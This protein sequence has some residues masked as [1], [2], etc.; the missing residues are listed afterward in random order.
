M[1]IN[2]VK[3]ALKERLDEIDKYMGNPPPFN[4]LK[5]TDMNNPIKVN[6]EYVRILDLEAEL[7]RMISA[8]EWLESKLLEAISVLNS[9]LEIEVLI[10]SPYKPLTIS[11]SKYLCPSD[12]SGSLGKISLEKP[13]LVNSCLV[14]LGNVDNK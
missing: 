11:G 6:K 4:L 8:S 9:N 1:E 7:R 13:K 14:F 2:S 12:L 3:Q 10:W 5:E